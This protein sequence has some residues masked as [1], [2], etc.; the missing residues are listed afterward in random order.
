MQVGIHPSSHQHNRRN[1][2]STHYYYEVG[3][4]SPLNA[5]LPRAVKD[6]VMCPTCSAPVRWARLLFVLAIALQIT[7]QIALSWLAHEIAVRADWD[8]WLLFGVVCVVTGFV[9]NPNRVV[10]SW[11][12]RLVENDIA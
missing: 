12:G 5:S 9:A 7:V 6:V 4:F 8:F 2:D 1:C 3:S 11:V 10:R